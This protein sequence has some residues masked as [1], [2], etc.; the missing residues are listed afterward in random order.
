VCCRQIFGKTPTQ[1][2]NTSITLRVGWL[3]GWFGDV[4]QTAGSTS[5]TGCL[6]SEYIATA[7]ASAC[8]PC[9]ASTIS[10]GGASVC[11]TCAAG[12]QLEGTTSCAPSG[13]CQPGWI[14]GTNGV[15]TQ[16]AAHTYSSIVAATICNDCPNGKNQVSNNLIKNDSLAACP[17][18]L[19]CN[20]RFI[21]SFHS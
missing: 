11:A 8:Q 7:G 1:T 9:A 12:L 5:C 4:T 17:P 3:V 6:P 16:C 18:S 21:L 20:N 2:T 15:C 19:Y 13:Q 10:L 14:A